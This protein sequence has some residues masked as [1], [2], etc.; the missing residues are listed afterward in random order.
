MA[1]E[2]SILAILEELLEKYGFSDVRIE[3]TI[4]SGSNSSSRTFILHV[5]EDDSRFL[6]GQYGNNLQ[7][8]Q[9]IARMMVGKSFPDDSWATFFLDVN[10]YRRKKDQSVIDLAKTASREAEKE[11]KVVVLRPMSAYERRL[12]H[13]ELSKEKNVTTESVGE[14]DDRR[15]VVRPLNI[16]ETKAE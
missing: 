6:I 9:H 15:I 10:D 11:G 16:T 13:L 3:E 1:Q 12:V 8:L 7:A 2:K 5:S 14:G 4:S